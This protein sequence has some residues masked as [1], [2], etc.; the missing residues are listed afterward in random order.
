M[1]YLLWFCTLTLTFQYLSFKYVLLKYSKRPPSY[2]HKLNSKILKVLPIAAILHMMIS[3]YIYGN[4]LIFPTADTRTRVVDT[5]T[6]VTV[7][8][9]SAEK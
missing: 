2:D 8:L 7:E 3:I 1:P 5:M 4:P 6:P 9:Y